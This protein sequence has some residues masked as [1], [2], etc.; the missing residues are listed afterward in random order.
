MMSNSLRDMEEVRRIILS[1]S[2]KGVITILSKRLSVLR[3][4]RI[5]KKPTVQ[6]VIAKTN[7]P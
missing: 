7:V 5:M 4:L 6:N 1:D 3:Y 2:L